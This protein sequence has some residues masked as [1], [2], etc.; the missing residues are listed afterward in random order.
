MKKIIITICIL[1]YF[2][3]I[4]AKQLPFQYKALMIIKTKTDL[5]IDGYPPIKCEM[6]KKDIST[7]SRAY[8][9]YFPYWVKKLSDNQINVECDV[10]VS[11]K[12]L[13]TVTPTGRAYFVH[14]NN[15]KDEIDLYVPLGKYDSIFTYWK[16]INYK[17]KKPF[18]TGFGWPLGPAVNANHCSY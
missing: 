13:S 7:V 4:S 11:E 16:A 3:Q 18:P 12:I 10:V 17:T 6:N 14:P 15:I 5:N 8:K 2:N 1:M 9:E